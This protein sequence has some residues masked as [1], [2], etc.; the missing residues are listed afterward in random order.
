MRRDANAIFE[1]NREI[2]NLQAAQE[3]Q[4]MSTV[5]I[6]AMTTTGAAK[7]RKSLEKLDAEIMIIEEAAEV[8]ESSI[9]TSLT[10]NIK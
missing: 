1:L 5:D 10:R 3:A 4:V 2:E 8:L 7:N 6:V 9:T